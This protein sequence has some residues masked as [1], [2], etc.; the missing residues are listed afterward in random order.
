MR[1]TTG[2]EIQIKD[3]RNPLRGLYKTENPKW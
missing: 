1:E 2:F 3:I